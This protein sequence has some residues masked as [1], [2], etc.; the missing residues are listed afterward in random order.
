MRRSCGG[1][2]QFSG[3]VLGQEGAG[4]GVDEVERGDG[5]ADHLAH[6][7]DPGVGDTARDDSAKP[8]QR[9]VAVDGEA[10]HRHSLLHAHPD[11]C[12]L[13]FGERP[14]H[15]DAASA[16][17]L[18]AVDAERAQHIDEHA[19]EP[20][21]MGDDIDGLDEADDR[22]SHELPGA[23]PG[24]LAAAVHVDHGSPVLWA[25]LRFR[26]LSRGVHRLMLEEDQ[27]VRTC[28]SDDIGVDTALKI[29][30]VEVRYGRRSESRGEDLEHRRTAFLE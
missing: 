29:P 26:P 21:H 1:S 3:R 18:I 6:R 10:V 20:A 11:R 30:S 25:L 5:G 7:R 28:T 12:D 23:V 27:C 17:H 8:G 22:I 13:V 9:V 19:L 15:P 2:C 16:V 14:A 4:D 24:D